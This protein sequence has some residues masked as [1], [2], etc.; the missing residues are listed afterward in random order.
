MFPPLIMAG[1]RTEKR[2]N[3]S[4]GGGEFC[5]LAGLAITAVGRR[6]PLRT[7]SGTM[8]GPRLRPFG[9]ITAPRVPPPPRLPSGYS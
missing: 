3:Q 9:S 1:R 2:S 6:V 7:F 4:T 8:F 5:R